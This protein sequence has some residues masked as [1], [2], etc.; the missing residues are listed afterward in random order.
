MRDPKE[1]VDEIE[2]LMKEYK[3]NDFEFFDLTAII[4]KSWILEFC[5]TIKNRGLNNITW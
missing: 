5:N 3:A 1:I 2:W 4:K